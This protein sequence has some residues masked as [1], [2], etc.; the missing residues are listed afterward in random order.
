LRWSTGESSLVLPVAAGEPYT[1]TLELSVPP[2]AVGPEAGLY[3]DDRR[4]A[5]L[6]AG[7]A[8]LT[9]ELP[10]AAGSQVRVEVR[11]AM[12]VPSKVVPGSGDDRSLGIS[13]SAVTVRARGA[14]RPRPFDANV[15]KWPE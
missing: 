8:T 15:G 1:L 13:L 4:L 14:V 10:P 3:I 7:A 2:G 12:W 9:A 5:P 6:A 11:S